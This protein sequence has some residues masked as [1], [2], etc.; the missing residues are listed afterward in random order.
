[1]SGK[2]PRTTLRIEISP[3]TIVYILVAITAVWLAFELATVLTVLIVALVLVGT[4]DPLVAWLERRGIRRGRALVLVFTILLL[5]I[6]TVLLL[7]IPPLVSQLLSMLESAPKIRSS[8]GS[9]STSG[10]SRSFSRSGPC[11]STTSS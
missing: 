6:A 7:T 11:R 3:R 2:P 1:V 5:A 9:A 10:P 8:S 4:L